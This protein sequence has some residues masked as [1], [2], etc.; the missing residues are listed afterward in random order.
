MAFFEAQDT[1]ESLKNILEQ[2]REIILSGNFSALEQLAAEKERLLKA[3]ARVKTDAETLA[4]LK[5]FSE[6]NALL[7]DAVRA[8]V[9]SALERL[10][11][12]REP[13]NN[14]RTYDQAGR[15]HDIA[16][17]QSQTGRRA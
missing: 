15:Q 11:A 6:R 4:E 2:E 3:L 13:R 10:R 1:H 17:E 12:L 8:G 16:V 7:Y 5:Q 14:L 9:G